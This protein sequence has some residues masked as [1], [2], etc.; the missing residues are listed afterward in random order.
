M[1]SNE[2]QQAQERLN[3][4]LEDLKNF[5][6]YRGRTVHSVKSLPRSSTVVHNIKSR[7][8]LMKEKVMIAM[9]NGS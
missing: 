4:S 2:M 3:T 8:F 6:F 9:H 7:Y 1:K 5:A